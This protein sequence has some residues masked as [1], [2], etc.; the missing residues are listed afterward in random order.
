MVQDLLYV[1]FYVF[2]N[3]FWGNGPL[4]ANKSSIGGL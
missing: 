3:F 2:S 4:Y 1:L